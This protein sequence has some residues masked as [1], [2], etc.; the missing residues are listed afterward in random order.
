MKG[1]IDRDFYCTGYP[2]PKQ[3]CHT[4]QMCGGCINDDT[5]CEFLHRKWPTPEQ[6]LEE[7][8]EEYPDNW[9]AY[10]AID[11]DG[12]DWEVTTLKEGLERV[13]WPTQWIGMVVC[14]CTPWGKPPYDWGTE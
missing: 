5:R 3:Q 14:A 13:K 4:L 7:Y 1:E 6:F 10:V 11:S 9:A 2:Y 8:G 12:A